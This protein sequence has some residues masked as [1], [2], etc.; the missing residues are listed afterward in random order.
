[1]ISLLCYK[2]LINCQTIYFN[3]DNQNF[4]NHK[5]TIDYTTC[6]HYF[7]DD[8]YEYEGEGDDEYAEEACMRWGYNILILINSIQIFVERIYLQKPM[9]KNTLEYSHAV[10]LWVTWVMEYAQ[11][12]VQV[13]VM[14]KWEIFL[15]AMIRSTLEK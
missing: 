12:P 3:Q 6:N 13:W 9:Q 1:M 10:M 15:F 4:F 2:R 14:S 8:V 5:I 11:E 7:Y